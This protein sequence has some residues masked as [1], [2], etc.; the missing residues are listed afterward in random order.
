MRKEAGRR[1]LQMETMNGL[2]VLHYEL[3][4]LQRDT[5]TAERYIERA[6]SEWREALLLQPSI[7]PIW[8]MWEMYKD[9]RSGVHHN[10]KQALALSRARSGDPNPSPRQLHRPSSGSARH[11]PR[12][13]I[14]RG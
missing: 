10:L 11:Q 9:A 2:G 12:A 6:I 7:M 13:T 14:P 3:S 8:N 4:L 1:D 5:A